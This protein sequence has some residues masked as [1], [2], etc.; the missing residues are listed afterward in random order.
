MVYLDDIDRLL[1][2]Y[3]G[4]AARATNAELADKVHMSQSATLRR[5]RRL[6]NE[7]IIESYTVVAN[8]S[9]IG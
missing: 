8:R 6:E 4:Q 3:L 1:L 5:V 9:A 7:G 2:G